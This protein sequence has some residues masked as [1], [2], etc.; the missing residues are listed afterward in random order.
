[1]YPA[2]KWNSRP[3]LRDKYSLFWFAWGQAPFLRPHS[4]K[5]LAPHSSINCHAAR[6]SAPG[7]LPGT[8]SL[9]NNHVLLCHFLSASPVSSWQVTELRQDSFKGPQVLSVCAEHVGQILVILLLLL[10]SKAYSPVK[11]WHCVSAYPAMTAHTLHSPLLA[12]LRTAAH[13]AHSSWAP[14]QLLFAWR[15]WSLCWFVQFLV[16][17]YMKDRV[18]VHDSTCQCINRSSGTIEELTP[19]SVVRS[20]GESN[21]IP[22]QYCTSCFGSQHRHL[23]ATI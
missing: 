16:L 10:M 8:L 22:K 2:R 1:M 7:S 23:Q 18:W 3:P 6:A 11:Q 21:L 14:G 9:G 17:C 12:I 13:A 20:K 19:G 5:H 4:E 15:W